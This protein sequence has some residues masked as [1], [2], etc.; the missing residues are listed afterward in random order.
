MAF[1]T[2]PFSRPV[3]FSRPQLPRRRELRPRERLGRLQG[4]RVP[5]QHRVPPPPASGTP[6]ARS[7][8]A[9]HVSQRLTVRPYLV[10]LG[11]SCP[12]EGAQRLGG[13]VKGRSPHTHHDHTSVTETRDYED[14][15]PRPF[16]SSD[17]L[18]RPAPP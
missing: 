3:P 5:L 17:V 9:A 12:V 8:H 13:A 15:P 16:H 10:F 4:D 2:P 1:V 11:S 14:Q 18:T 7:R 6:A